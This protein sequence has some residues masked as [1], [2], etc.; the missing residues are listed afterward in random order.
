M[1]LLTSGFTSMIYLHSLFF[2]I[3]ST[4]YIKEI[5][6]FFACMYSILQ[7]PKCC[8]I[9]IFG[10]YFLYYIYIFPNFYT[11]PTCRKTNP[12][13][14]LC[15]HFTLCNEYLLIDIYTN[16]F[17]MINIQPFLF[18]KFKYNNT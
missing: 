2:Q 14:F 5:T 3:I 4:R 10:K 15:L 13:S 16:K 6:L 18:N 17:A 8:D 12:L 9:R 7:F 1:E 11:L